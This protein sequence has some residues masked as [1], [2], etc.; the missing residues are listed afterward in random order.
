MIAN[1]TLFS[2]AILPSL[3]FSLSVRNF[4]DRRYEDPATTDHR[5]SLIAQ[6]GRTFRG[7]ATYRF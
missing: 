4:P 2:A 7:Q 1:A 5:Q 3:D 6:D